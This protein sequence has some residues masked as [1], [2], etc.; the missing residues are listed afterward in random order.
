M[1]SDVA[2][3]S[4]VAEAFEKNLSDYYN[5]GKP[6]L[7]VWKIWIQ[8]VFFNERKFYLFYVCEIRDNKMVKKS[9]WLNECGKPTG[10]LSFF[11]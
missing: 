6:C 9:L 4:L 7:K 1:P 10:W 11:F 8:G 5:N 2:V 3:I